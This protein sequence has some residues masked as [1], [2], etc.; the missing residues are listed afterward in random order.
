MKT[1]I[2]KQS[3]TLILTHADE[4]VKQQE[5]S[6]IAGRSAK[7]H[8]HP[9][10]TVWQCLMKVNTFFQ[11]TP[12]IVPLVVTINGFKTSIYQKPIHRCLW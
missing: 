1:S 12:T 7:G 11:H 9:W 10:K 6:F 5:F 4:A 3:P 2:K 8:S